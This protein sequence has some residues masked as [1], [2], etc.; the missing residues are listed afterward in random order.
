MGAI[1]DILDAVRERGAITRAELIDDWG[2]KLEEYAELLAAARTTADVVPRRGRIGGLESA[3]PNTR[4]ASQTVESDEADDEILASVLATLESSRSLTRA[5]VCAFAGLNGKEEYVAFAKRLEAYALERRRVVDR[6]KGVGGLC[7]RE[8]AQE[9]YRRLLHSEERRLTTARIKALSGAEGSD[10]YRMLLDEIEAVAGSDG[11]RLKRLKGPGGV[12]V[13]PTM[14]E[15]LHGLRLRKSLRQNELIELAEIDPDGYPQFVEALLAEAR[16]SGLKV[17]PMLGHPGG[18]EVREDI[19]ADEGRPEG[20]ALEPWQQAAVEVLAELA[21]SKLEELAGDALYNAVR[22]LSGRRGRRPVATAIV[23]RL[24]VDLLA[25]TEVREALATNKGIEAP[26]RWHAGGRAAQR[27]VEALGLP[28]RFAGE[29]ADEQRPDIQI[30]E[31]RLRLRD[32]E[33]FQKSVRTQ[34]LERLESP[35]ARA[36]VSLPTGAGKTRVAVDTIRTLLTREYD[37]QTLS[38]ANARGVV[39]WLAHTDELCEQACQCIIDVWA[40]SPE[41]CPLGLVR[42][43]G[44]YSDFSVKHEDVTARLDSP[45]VIVSTPQR[46]DN[47]RRKANVEN[48]QRSEEFLTRLQRALRLIVIDEAHRA[49][50]PI[51]RRIADYYDTGEPG[52]VG[53]TATPFRN[54]GAPEAGAQELQAIFHE[55]VE[56]QVIGT[57]ENPDSQQLRRALQQRGVLAEPSFEEILTNVNLGR[58]EDEPETLAEI[59]AI[60]QQLRNRAD[61]PA[62]RDA[63]LA[64]ILPIA[65][66]D[67]TSIIYFGPTVKD[68]EIMAYML[69]YHGV[70]AAVVSG[71]TRDPARKQ[72]ISQFKEGRVKVLCNCEVLTTGFDHPPITHVVIARPTMSQVLYEQMVGR[73]LR[74]VRFGGTPTCEILDCLDSFPGGG[75]PQLGFDRFREAWGLA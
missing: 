14:S 64:R 8:N 31:G 30:L 60:D 35:G 51:Y 22:R 56:P 74:G 12:A 75:R 29:R 24:G 20:A 3:L 47:I 72:A 21:P 7:L 70:P 48:V 10:G 44:H 1:E 50:A 54:V 28:S 15:V 57:L 18:F 34:L 40:D 36:L 53:L 63:V 65:R 5:E 4:E 2:L 55:L 73:G 46:L 45:C 62:R 6:K 39:L 13:V 52:V 61:V 49:A 71:S 58:I 42:F 25:D 9:L 66:K 38:S 26:G 16:A 27:F 23:L 67:G 33:D 11:R 17:E 59:N 19:Q 69:Q 68:S 32:L 43:W 37:P 41:A